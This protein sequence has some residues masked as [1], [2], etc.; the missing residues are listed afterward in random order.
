MLIELLFLITITL[1]FIRGIR[2]WASRL[3]L[4]DI[5]N[6]RSIHL[7]AT[8]RGAGIAFVAA[9]LLDLIFFHF[10]LVLEHLP[11]LFAL[12]MVWVV[13]ILDDRHSVPP[14]LKFLVLGAATLLLGE[15]GLFIDNVGYYIGQDVH[16]SWLSI[17]FTLFAV[18]GFSNALNLIDGLDGL[19][20]SLS[21]V[22]LGAFVFVGWE[23]RD[24]F[25]LLLSSLFILVLAIFLFFNWHPASIFMG[26]SGSLTLGFLISI[27]AIHALNYIPSVSILYLVTIPLLDTLVAMIRRKMHGRST[28]APD[29]CH[30][31]HLI[32]RRTG[33]VH[34]TVLILA[35][36][37]LLFTGFGLLLPKGMDQTLAL[38]L[39]GVLVYL[40][41]RWVE[42]MIETM[43]I[44]CYVP[45]NG[46][47]A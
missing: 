28:T 14:K 43:Q 35:A 46:D 44:D 9:V 30:L 41:Y 2:D 26:D 31:H 6:R 23:H 8:P 1:L 3:H 16:L 29:R 27:L 7:D 39:F 34:K 22:I 42:K 47:K 18:V 38:L 19:A 5:P 33:S 10:S 36:A 13:G 24:A 20:A 11:T 25:L 37:Q 32:L 15:D 45:R 4:V 17:P 21:I 12:M 40:S